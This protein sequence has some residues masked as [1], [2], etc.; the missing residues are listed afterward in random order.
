MLKQRRNKALILINNLNNPLKL[1]NKD[2]FRVIV[3]KDINRQH[4][5]IKE[6][7]RFLINMHN[8]Y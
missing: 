5:N 2:V 6:Y 4:Y 7:F 8:T 1:R 3:V